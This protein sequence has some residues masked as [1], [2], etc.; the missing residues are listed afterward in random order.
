MLSKLLPSL[1]DKLTPNGLLEEPPPALEQNK[2]PGH[3]RWSFSPLLTLIPSS[4]KEGC[5]HDSP[6]FR[7]RKMGGRCAPGVRPDLRID[8]RDERPGPR[9]RRGSKAKAKA[10][11]KAKDADSAKIDINKAT[12]EEMINALPGVG[13]ATAKKIIAGRPYTSIDGLEKAGVPARTVEAIRPLIV[14]APETTKAEPKAKAK[15]KTATKAATTDAAP[16]GKVNLNT[17]IRRGTGNASRHRCGSCHGDHRRAALQE[18]GRPRKDQGTRRDADRGLEGARDR[19]RSGPGSH[20]HFYANPRSDAPTAKPATKAMTKTAGTTTKAFSI[21]PAKPKLEPGERININ[22]AS[23]DDLE[24]LFGIGPVKAQAIIEYR[25]EIP[26]K[27]VDDIMKVKGIKE[28][29]F[30]KIK[31]RIKVN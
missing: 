28:G 10:K 13:E 9:G 18:R 31:D 22:T 15:A 1:V 21:T 3:E 25:K 26:F 8:A 5:S 16:T 24:R 2:R 20:T 19:R 11:T 4:V 23:Q 27:T 30:A 12:A 29:E 7:S 17:A 14:L 6:V